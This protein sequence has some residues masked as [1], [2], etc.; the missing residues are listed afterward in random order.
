MNSEGHDAAREELGS[1]LD[2]LVSSCALKTAAV[3]TRDGS[4]VTDR[5]DTSYLDTTALA[6]LLGGMFSATREVARMVG[7]EHFSILLQQG[8]K[9]HIHISLIGDEF[10]LTC[11]FEDVA[12]IGMLRVQTRRVSPRIGELASVGFVASAAADAPAP[13]APSATREPSKQ[14]SE[15]REYA[16]DLIDRIFA[17]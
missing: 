14:G 11:V 10:M 8:E 3:V 15:F 13:G 1:I 17:E 4:L 5:G 2:G 9:R 7:E 6:A 12:K 16:L